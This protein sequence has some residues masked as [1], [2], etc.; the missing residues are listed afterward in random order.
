[1]DE[2]ALALLARGDRESALK[3]ALRAHGPG[4]LG[5]LENVLGDP[6][7]ARDVFQRCAEDLWAWLPAYRGGSLRAAAYRIARHRAAR[8]R[9]EAW[10]RRR[11]RMRTTMA[12]RIAASIASPESRLATRP[13]D[14]LERLRAALDPDER[15]LLI[16]RLDRELSWSEVAE[17][18]SEEGHPVDSATV[19][20]RF[21][22]VKD[23]LA[24]LA[25]EQGLL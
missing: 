1:M 20:K 11:E 21:E 14:R 6:D 5:Y 17:V 8:F 10:R 9:R 18:L 22:R 3:L 2:E 13:Q 24:K 15:T 12:S 23:R 16:L 7:D 4:V 19:R 25:K